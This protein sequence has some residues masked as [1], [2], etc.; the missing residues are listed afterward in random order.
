V[1]G[2]NLHLPSASAAAGAAMPR[3]FGYHSTLFA[4]SQT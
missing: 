2:L 4:G 1:A 3:R